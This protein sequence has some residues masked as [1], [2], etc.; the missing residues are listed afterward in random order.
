M[1]VSV[2]TTH[3]MLV[4]WGAYAQSIGLVEKLEK[5]PVTQQSRDHTPQ[6]S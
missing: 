1:P 6:T 2:V 4:A 5:V 3:A